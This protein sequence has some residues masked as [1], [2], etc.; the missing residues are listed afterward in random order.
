MKRATLS[1]LAVASFFFGVPAC[2]GGDRPP[3]AERKAIESAAHSAKQIDIKDAHFV[4]SEACASCHEPESVAWKASHH[5][6]AMQK[7]TEQTVLGDFGEIRV[8][9]GSESARFYQRDDD[10]FV[11]LADRDRKMHEYEV[12]YTF[13]VSPLQ[14]YLVKTERGRLQVIPF[15]WDTRK[16]AD[17][18]QR[19]FH[20]QEVRRS[21]LDDPLHW[22]GNFYNW[23]SNC[24][25]CHSTNVQKNYDRA[26]QSY[27][28]Q[29]D[30]IDVGCEAC[31]GPA[32]NHV[33]AAKA[34]HAANAPLALSKINNRRWIFEHDAP[35]ASLSSPGSASAQLERC[36]V[37]HSR[38]SDLGGEGDYHDRYRLSLLHAPLYYDDGQIRDEVF[39]Y[40]SFLQSKMHAAGVVCTDCHDAHSTKTKLDGNALCAKCHRADVYDRPEHS[41]HAKGSV[42]AQ[43]VECHMP[44][45]TYMRVDDRR[46]HR[47]GIPR[48]DLSATFGVLNAC[49]NCHAN[50]D[51]AWAAKKLE[52]H[53]G[54]PPNEA[55]VDQLLRI[56][57]D[58]TMDPRQIVMFITSKSVPAIVR[59]SMIEEL[60]SLN[61]L[62]LESLLRNTLRDEN[63]LIRRA[64]AN[65]AHRLAPERRQ[66][67]LASLLRDPVRVVRVEAASALIDTDKSSFSETERRAFESA[68]KDYRAAREFNADSPQGLIDLAHLS[69]TEGRLDSAQKDLLEA[70]TIDPTYAIAYANLADLYRHLGRETD[71]IALLQHALG[72]IYDKALVHH[73]LGL[74]Y[75]RNKQP[76]NA[77]EHMEKAYRLQPTN[78]RYGYV[79]AIALHDGGEKAAAIK[80]LNS[81]QKANPDDINI[82]QLLEQYTQKPP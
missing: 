2:K 33:A 13:G 48:P 17:G 26:T 24:A 81:V 64:S 10:F 43:C 54:R 65:A 68:L 15:A 56:R 31:H 27:Q 52:S 82:R 70:I 22:T 50:H 23:N 7:A 55:T 8:K 41:M 36:A 9:Q 19:W 74:A 47:F 75:V 66:K 77:L 4:G 40:G 45:T 35:I 1:T 14:Q 62:S 18:G 79:Y 42:G 44:S 11:E 38:R 29:F 32:S 51:A 5:D 57:S 80:V 60:A 37:C 61:A 12:L 72:S 63:P 20:V 39:V 6:R 76:K 67:F 78:P 49:T 25:D 59:A 34:G 53:F 21:T 30:E 58:P 69:A 46:D 3:N 28:T 71:G 16:K 73:A